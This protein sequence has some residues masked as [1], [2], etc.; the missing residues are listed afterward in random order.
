MFEVVQGEAS[1]ES[2]SLQ[3]LEGV[4]AGDKRY[5]RLQSRGIRPTR[6][7]LVEPDWSFL[8]FFE[9]IRKTG[10]REIVL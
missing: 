3:D 4:P 2:I 9:K 6:T 8:K 5:S 10:D 1:P 7:R